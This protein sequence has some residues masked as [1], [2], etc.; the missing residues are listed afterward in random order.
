MRRDSNCYAYLPHLPAP[1]TLHG[2]KLARPLVLICVGIRQV[3]AKRYVP[4]GLY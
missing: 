3:F 4:L 2:W 1:I